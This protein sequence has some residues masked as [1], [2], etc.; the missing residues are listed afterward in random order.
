MPLK[1]VSF[2]RIV[3]FI[4][5]FIDFI[6]PFREISPKIRYFFNISIFEICPVFASIPK[7]MLK[8]K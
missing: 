6:F 4:A 1:F 8:S 5:P 2:A 7:N 3:A